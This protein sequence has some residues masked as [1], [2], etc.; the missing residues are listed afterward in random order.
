MDAPGQWDVDQRKRTNFL[1]TTHSSYFD[2][3]HIASEAY[4]V[5]QLR[6]AGFPQDVKG[7]MCYELRMISVIFRTFTVFLYKSEEIWFLY[8]GYLVVV[9]R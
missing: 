4:L 7:A 5:F 2:S 9:S 1:P 8:R 6:F 3:L